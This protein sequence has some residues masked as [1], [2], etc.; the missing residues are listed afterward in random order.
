M[1]N[2][3][4]GSGFVLFKD[5]TISEGRPLIL[6]LIREDGQYDLPKGVNEPGESSLDSARR[7]C[8]EECSI[9]VDDNELLELDPLTYGKLTMFAAET[10]KEPIITRNAKTGILEHAG[11]EWVNPEQFYQKCLKYLEHSV[12]HFCKELNVQ[13]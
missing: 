8:F 9:F 3:P 6:V 13:K 10:A 7:E 1:N 4:A 5:G 2:V 12:R 11:S